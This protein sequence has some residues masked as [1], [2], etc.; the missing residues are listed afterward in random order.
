MSLLM[1]VF[2]AVLLA[3]VISCLLARR[4]P[5][6]SPWILVLVAAAGSCGIATLALILFWSTIRMR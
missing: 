4:F 2:A 1:F 5:R 3:S 6:V